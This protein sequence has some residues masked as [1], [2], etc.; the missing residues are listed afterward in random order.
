ML[1]FLPDSQIGQITAE[2]VVSDCTGH[3]YRTV[4]VPSG[5]E[6]VGM[7]QHPADPLQIIYWTA[8]SGADEEF[9]SLHRFKRSI[10]S[11]SDSHNGYTPQSY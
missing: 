1:V 6:N 3:T 11:V 4:I 2:S 10:D 9:C 5:D 7:L 8:K